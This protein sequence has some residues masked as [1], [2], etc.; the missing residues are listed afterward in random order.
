M[1]ILQ[2]AAD[3]MLLLLAEIGIDLECGFAQ[4]M[5]ERASVPPRVWSPRCR[6]NKEIRLEIFQVTYSTAVSHI[7]WQRNASMYSVCTH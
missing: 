1:F 4:W 2:L 3:E 6:F 7:S 5:S